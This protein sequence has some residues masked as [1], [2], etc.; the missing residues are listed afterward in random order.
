MAAGVTVIP[1]IFEKA[2]EM[3]QTD[4][5]QTGLPESSGRIQ[6]KT[7]SLYESL[8]EVDAREASSYQEKCR[9][10]ALCSP[11]Y[12]QRHCRAADITRKNMIRLADRTT[13]QGIRTTWAMAIKY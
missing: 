4:P 2:E 1:A 11:Q 6:A 8:Y 3:Q 7:Q 9:T 5:R 12:A 10:S 13:S